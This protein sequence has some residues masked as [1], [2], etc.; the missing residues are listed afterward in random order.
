MGEKESNT[1]AGSETE[2]QTPKRDFGDRTGAGSAG[3]DQSA[4]E[5]VA[6]ESTGGAGGEASKGLNAVNV[7]LA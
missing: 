7:K 2:R 1:E 6:K 3:G 4:G 5:S